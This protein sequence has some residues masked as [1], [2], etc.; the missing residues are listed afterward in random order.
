MKFK[1]GKRII[2]YALGFNDVSIVPSSITIDP[3]DVST[4]VKIGKHEFQLPFLAA[5]MDGVVDV[6]FAEA[7]GKLGGLAVLNLHGLQTRYEKPQEAIKKITSLKSAQITPA[8]QK[9][10]K[11]KIKETLIR[12]RI[13]EIK[14][15]NIICAFS[16]IPQDAERFGEIAQD[17]G[18][19]IFIV[20][21]T[22]TSIRHYSSKQKSLDLKK[23]CKNLK[24]PVIIGNC[25]TYKVA[26]E[27]MN[28]GAAGILVGIGPGAACT[29]RAVLGVGTPQVTATLETAAA[30]DDFYEKTGKYVP[31]ITDG[32][33]VVGGDVVKAF[34][35][36]ADAVMLGSIFA[37]SKE[38]AGKGYHW[39]MAT[40]HEALPR[41]TRVFVGIHGTLEN[42]LLGPSR[43]D[44]G[45]QNLVGSLKT[46]MG[47]CGAKNIREFHKVH[48]VASASFISEGK[49]Y[50][51]QQN[52]GTKK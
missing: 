28:A 47:V 13:R 49:S 45:S 1:V 8:I 27:L 15:H 51:F 37:R 36:G 14:K 41:G 16:S 7:L 18:A 52:V 35:S 31:I 4:T 43:V 9:L 39:G 22:V 21:S 48:I 30:R 33:M 42:I 23:L 11:A 44:D 46:A 38:A 5:A 3:D 24:I 25:V 40:S 20:Q 29:T 17:E 32:G 6:K 50:Q 12:K 10:Y 26:N 2:P 19:D 34:A